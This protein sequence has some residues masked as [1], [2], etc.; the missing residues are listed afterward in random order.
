MLLLDEFEDL[1]GSRANS[2]RALDSI[3]ELNGL[4]R[5]HCLLLLVVAFKAGCI[6]DRSVGLVV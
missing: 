6:A 5:I 3:L 4:W 1:H 2:D